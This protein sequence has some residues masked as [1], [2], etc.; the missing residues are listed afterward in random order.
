MTQATTNHSTNHSTRMLHQY[1]GREFV[2]I[3]LTT[4]VPPV[5]GPVGYRIIGTNR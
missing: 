3:P 4:E 2:Q 5:R 1:L